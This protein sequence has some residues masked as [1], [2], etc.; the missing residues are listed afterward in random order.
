MPK[1]IDPKAIVKRLKA[2]EA[3][4]EK[5]NI[6]YRLSKTI[7]DQ[8]KRECDRQDVVPSHVLEEFMMAFVASSKN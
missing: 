1:T 7:A 4:K 2:K 3:G 8:F 5:A 6:T